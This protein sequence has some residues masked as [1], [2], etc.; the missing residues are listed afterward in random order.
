MKAIEYKGEERE[1]RGLKRGNSKRE[2]IKR[3]R[4]REKINNINYG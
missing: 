3:N 2:N 4:Y 1:A